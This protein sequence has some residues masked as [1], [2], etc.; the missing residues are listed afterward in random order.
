MLF[1]SFIYLFLFLP[2]SICIYFIL[3]KKKYLKIAR[4]WLIVASFFYYGW[5]KPWFVF[6]FL[7]SIFTN[8][9]VGK[10]IIKWRDSSPQYTKVFL[11][12]G[13]IFNIGLLGFFKY[14][15]FVILNVNYFLPHDISFLNII[16][17]LGISFFTFIQ[18]AYLVDTSRNETGEENLLNYF[19]FTSF[20]PHIFSGPIVRHKEIMAQHHNE[21]NWSLN[22]DMIAKGLF[23]FALGLFKK[24]MVA[25]NLA[26]IVNGGFA[27]SG[28]L[29]FIEAWVTSIGYTFQLYFDFSG[30]TD[31]AIGS[32][33]MFNITLPIN[34]DSPY[35]ALNIQDFWRRWHI[36]LSNF[37]RDYIY[38]PLGGNRKG[39]IKTMAN[40][41]ITFLIGGIW[42]GAG[43]TFV[44]WGFLH[45]LGL[46][47]KRIWDKTGFTMSKGLAIFLTFNYVNIA[48]IFFRARNFSEAVN[49]LKGMFGLQGFKLPTLFGN[50]SFL[51]NISFLTIT[52][53][54]LQGGDFKTVIFLGVILIICLKM[55]NTNEYLEKFKPTLLHA[56]IIALLLFSSI[57][58]FS[59]FSSFIYYVF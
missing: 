5:L 3:Q 43:W 11:A 33:M 21:K 4:I 12:S 10:A 2:L 24:V 15:N 41:M 57:L 14:C 32:A 18:I 48:W 36:T 49:I 58:Y 1:N 37:L 28:E 31:M 52:D 46:V 47:A 7:I 53:N 40:V 26:P 50:L 29:T 19:L 30:Y 6:V 51:N 35:K 13:I 25:D 22:S 34:F 59:R 39:E 45:G 16:F 56:I 44:F 38:I 42:H 55:R 8:F 27:L 9:L 17:P 54:W 23:I 20:F